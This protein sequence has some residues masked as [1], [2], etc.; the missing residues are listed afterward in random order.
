MRKEDRMPAK[1]KKSQ[2]TQYNMKRPTTT[3][4]RYSVCDPGGCIESRLYTEKQ[5]RQY[6]LNEKKTLHNRNR[7]VTVWRYD[8]TPGASY[9]ELIATY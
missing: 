7:P 9:S 3:M 8:D 1:P 4:M 6:A 2:N 5:A